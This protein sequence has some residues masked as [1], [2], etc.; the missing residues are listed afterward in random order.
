[1]QVLHQ[2]AWPSYADT[3]NLLPDSFSG[4]IPEELLAIDRWPKLG[5]LVAPSF[6]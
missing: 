5:P 1:M 4:T 3:T 2:E 6:G